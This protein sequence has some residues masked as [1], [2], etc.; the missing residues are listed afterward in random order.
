MSLLQ[1]ARAA[2]KGR[3]AQRL[4][5][6]F[7]TQRVGGSSPSSPTIA[8]RLKNKAASGT[9]FLAYNIL[10]SPAIKLASLPLRRKSIP[11]KKRQPKQILLN[12]DKGTAQNP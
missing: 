2:E 4:A 7:Y 1:F 8:K 10:S 5:Q 6:L 12:I 11:I 9:L 3:L